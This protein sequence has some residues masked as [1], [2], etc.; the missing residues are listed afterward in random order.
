MITCLQDTHP[1]RP[2]IPAIRDQQFSPGNMLLS[3]LLLCINIP[4]S[5]LAFPLPLPTRPLPSCIYNTFTHL[6]AC[7]KNILSRIFRCYAQEGIS[8]DIW[9]TTAG[10]TS[11]FTLYALASPFPL[12]PLPSNQL[13]VTCRPLSRGPGPAPVSSPHTFLCSGPLLSYPNTNFQIS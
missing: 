7:F 12:G 6:M 13:P 3:V 10:H 8:L 1:F 11:D 5:F 2:L 4:P 9:F